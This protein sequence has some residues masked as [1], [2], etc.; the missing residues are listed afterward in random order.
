MSLQILRS[1]SFSGVIVPNDVARCRLGMAR[2]LCVVD[3]QIECFQRQYF[4]DQFERCL[5]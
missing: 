5:R 4:V 3:H 2:Y 1:I